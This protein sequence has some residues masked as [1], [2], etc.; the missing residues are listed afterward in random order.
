MTQACTYLDGALLEQAVHAAPGEAALAAR[1]HAPSC[2]QCGAA[3]D[4]YRGML[5]VWRRPDVQLSDVARSRVLDQVLRD[6]GAEPGLSQG[7]EKEAPPQVTATAED[8]IEIP[9]A[10]PLGPNLEHVGDYFDA[11]ML[12]FSTDASHSETAGPD[13]L[14]IVDF[15]PTRT[16]SLRKTLAVGAAV[17][18]VTFVALVGVY[19]DSQ[20]SRELAEL[21]AGVRSAMHDD[22]FAGYRSALKLGARGL[23]IDAD[24]NQILSAMAYAE[25][26]LGTEHR[27]GGATERSRVYLNEAIATGERDTELR[28]AAS[29]LLA[30]HGGELQD[31]LDELW[32][33]QRLGGSAPLIELEGFHLRHT[34]APGGEETRR[35][36]ARLRESVVSEARAYNALGWYYF[37]REDWRLADQYFSEAIK[38]SRHHAGAL[39]G[40]ALTDLDRNIGIQERQKEIAERID[41]VF[42]MPQA[43]LSEPIR[44]LAHFSRSQLR[45]WQGRWEDADG[46]LKIAMQLEPDN[47]SFH[48]TRG[49]SLLRL[50]RPGEAIASLRKA[51]ALDP[52]NHRIQRYLAEAYVGC[53]LTFAAGDAVDRSAQLSGCRDFE[54]ELIEGDRL[55]VERV[56]QLAIRQ[57]ERIPPG[58]GVGV[59]TRA[60]I[61]ISKVH[62]ARKSPARAIAHMA[63][64]LE[65]AP[66]DLGPDHTAEAWCELGR[67]YEGTRKKAKA[68]Q[69]YSTGI[70]EY[71]YYPGCHFY[72]C[73]ALDR[74]SPQKRDACERYLRLAPY[75][76]HAKEVRKI[77]ERTR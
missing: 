72:L 36:L 15:V 66:V 21:Y 35:Q 39:L 20:Q 19:R 31:G 56:W 22:T 24:H 6:V 10:P 38:N 44:A 63:K 60:Q 28:V 26:V 29:L 59:Y 2:S 67:A 1:V 46:D 48:W 30:A 25:A 9:A 69:C 14:T 75:G 40:Q 11:E 62:R 23:T 12:G 34:A 73:H 18:V 76:E 4:T 55:R 57:Y 71:L 49:R 27:V 50:R 17:S 51:A 58:A 70:E 13:R 68:I 7:L 8:E 74:R 77:L 5:D 54:L 43:A 65:N 53:G 37:G 52:T 42:A 33:I 16:G 3:L 41:T 32:R 64:F 61:G 45:Q 47:V